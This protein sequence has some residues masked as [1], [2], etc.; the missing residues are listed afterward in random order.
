SKNLA[1]FNLRKSLSLHLRRLNP[2]CDSESAENPTYAILAFSI[3]VGFQGKQGEKF[4]PA[5]AAKKETC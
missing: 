1:D 5:V 3:C 2:D 4:S